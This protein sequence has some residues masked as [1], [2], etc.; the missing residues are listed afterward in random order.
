MSKPYEYAD[1]LIE[2]LRHVGNSA[3]QNAT[4][5][6]FDELNVLR[7]K[8][9]VRTLYADLMRYNRSILRRAA[10]K[11]YEDAIE[12]A[13]EKGYERENVTPSRK[14]A[15]DILTAL[16]AAYHPTTGYI[17]SKEMSRKRDRLFEEIVSQPKRTAVCAAYAH[18]AKLWF[19]QSRQYV[20]LAVDAARAEAFEQMGVQEVEWVA[21]KDARVCHE[22]HELDGA[23]FDIEHVPPKHRNCRCYLR[24]V[25]RGTNK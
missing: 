6:A 22:C 9:Q 11:A 3:F 12:E 16:L 20:D 19:G 14:A 23:R 13:R 7:V 2:R 17:Y 15:S 10:R 8:A 21:Q 24:P 1:E 18:A 4:L 5:T 25:R